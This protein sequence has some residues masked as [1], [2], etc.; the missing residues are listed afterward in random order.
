MGQPDTA[1]TTSVTSSDNP[2]LLGRAVQFTATVTPAVSKNPAPTG[3]VQFAIDG[4]VV[5]SP[6]PLVDGV[7]TSPG[8]TT[9]AHGQHAV[10]A[11]YTGSPASSPSSGSLTQT[12]YATVDV[13]CQVPALIADI[14]A[15]VRGERCRWPPDAPTNSPPRTLPMGSPACR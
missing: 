11:T 8:I 15:A 3:D 1:T 14:H 5:G 6:V 10:V 4:K 2:S 9:L 13:P 12:V 7:A